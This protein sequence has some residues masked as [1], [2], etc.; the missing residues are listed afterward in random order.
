M[1]RL[2]KK[3]LK[4]TA[5][6]LPLFLIAGWF[7][8]WSLMSA[9][10]ERQS[11]SAEIRLTHVGGSVYLVDAELDGR[12][13]GSSLAAS[14]GPDGVLLVDTPVTSALAR[15]VRQA[16]DELGAGEVRWVVNTH[17]HP[18]HVRGN[19]VFAPTATIV[20]HERT[21][22]RM[23]RPVRPFWWLPPV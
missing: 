17:P 16:L 6:M 10:M 2:L 5:I 20:A 13:V 19:A 11:S 21:R 4:I 12:Q 8:F 9:L 3:A 14:V 7:S 15:K 23:A 22:D 1:K 18:D